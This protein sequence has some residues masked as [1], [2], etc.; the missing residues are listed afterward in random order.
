MSQDQ[1]VELLRDVTLPLDP[2]DRLTGV[3][4]RVRRAEARRT[5]VLACGLA[6]VLVAGVVGAFTVS[7]RDDDVSLTDVADA[8]AGAGSFRVV[9]AAE[10]TVPGTS[11]YSAVRLRYSSDVDTDRD[12]SMSRLTFEPVE[13]GAFEG[14]DL[15][16]EARQIGDDLWIKM[17]G[18]PFGGVELP[19]EQRR[20]PWQHLT[21]AASGAAELQ[22]LSPQGL[23]ATVR[24][25]EHV[26]DLPDAEVDGDAVSRYVVRVAG[27]VFAG[28]DTAAAAADRP[29]PHDAEV[30]VDRQGRLRRISGEQVT[31]TGDERVRSRYTITFSDFGLDVRVSPP[32]PDQV[33]EAD[34]SSGSSSGTSEEVVG[35]G[36]T[37]TGSTGGSDPCEAVAR[38]ER[39]AEQGSFQAG[40]AKDREAFDRLLEGLREQCARQ[41]QPAG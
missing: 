12:V 20:R 1:V 28:P 40:S 4:D 41:Q 31:P 5:S 27:D 39:V 3:R 19:E 7:G 11:A 29:E 2:A 22:Q 34:V 6:A 23:L 15:G 26:R 25:S 10:S 36:E 16:Q 21:V 35:G 17:T 37:G 32:D 8:T 13:T 33:R 30:A 18:D 24:R 9:V 38:F 14:M